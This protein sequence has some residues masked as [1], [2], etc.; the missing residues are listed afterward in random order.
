M[1]YLFAFLGS[2]LTLMILGAIA[3][4]LFGERLPEIVRLFG[5]ELMEVKNGVRG[6]QREIEDTV[7]S[8]IS[9]PPRS[10]QQP[11]DPDEATVPKVDSSS[12]P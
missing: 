2:P 1:S 12:S 10:N 3:V 7:P 8:A 4:L 5:K 6:I 11:A 9:A